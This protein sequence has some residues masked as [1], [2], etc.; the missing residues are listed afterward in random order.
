MKRSEP[1]GLDRRRVQQLL[2]A[3]KSATRASSR[4]DRISSNLVGKPYVVNPLIGSAETPET[5]TIDMHRFDCVTLVETVLALAQ[6]KNAG[7]FIDRLRRIR[8]EDGRIEWKRR[9]HYMTQWIRNNIA[10]GFVQRIP[11]LKPIVTRKRILDMIPGLPPRSAA[12]SC[13]PKRYL[14]RSVDKLESGD[15]IFCASTRKRLDIFHCGIIVKN[16]R[17]LLVRNAAKS[18][19][20]VVEEKLEDFLKRNRMAGVLLVRPAEAQ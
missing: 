10:A 18:R 19:G 2:E 7:R 17:G 6:S 14:L 1:L 16:G 13:I 4:I 15:L 9:N 5:F 3:A 8:Y 20:A 12:F 11:A